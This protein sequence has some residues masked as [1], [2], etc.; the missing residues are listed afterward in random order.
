MNHTFSSVHC[1][2]YCHN[3]NPVITAKY[4]HTRTVSSVK[5]T[6]V[7]KPQTRYMKHKMSLRNDLDIYSD[8]TELFQRHYKPAVVNYIG[9]II[10]VLT[11]DGW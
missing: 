3:N 5:Q 2:L 7:I 4:S 1:G 8:V 9:D 11:Y 10:T 6:I